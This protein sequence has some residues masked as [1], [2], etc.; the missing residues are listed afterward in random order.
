MICFTSRNT[1]ILSIYDALQSCC[2][3]IGES[4]HQNLDGVRL[5]LSLFENT[6][7]SPT[8]TDWPVILEFLAIAM[9][10]SAQSS[11]SVFEL[12]KLQVL[13]GSGRERTS[14]L[15]RALSLAICIRSGVK[16]LPF[17]PRRQYSFMTGLD[18]RLPIRSEEVPAVRH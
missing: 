1:P 16:L 6:L 3:I 15:S 18:V 4:R 12:G 7:H 14:I 13:T 5:S 10:D 9:K 8:T 17:Q 2:I 11:R